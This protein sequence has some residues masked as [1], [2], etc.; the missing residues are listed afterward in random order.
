[1]RAAALQ[2]CAPRV[3]ESAVLEAAAPDRA[4]QWGCKG[5]NVRSSLPQKTLLTLTVHT[6]K[7]VLGFL[8]C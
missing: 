1:M 4:G 7:Q 6:R 8:K 3:A 5:T 2:A